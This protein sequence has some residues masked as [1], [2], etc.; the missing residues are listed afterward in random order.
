ML[1]KKAVMLD[2]HMLTH[3]ESLLPFIYTDLLAEYAGDHQMCCFHFWKMEHQVILGMKDTRVASLKEGVQSIKNNS[4]QVVVRNSGGLAVVAD[5]GILNFSIIL[6]QPTDKYS[7]SIDQGY[8]LMKSIIEGAF[9]EFEMDIEAFEVSD[10]YCPGDFD[11]SIN[12][13]KFAG[14]SQRRIKNG[15]GIMIYLSICGDQNKRSEIV[16]EF[17]QTSLGENFGTDGFPPVNPDSMANLSDLLQANL[18]VED[19]KERISH[20]LNQTFDFSE[21]YEQTFKEFLISTEFNDKFEK[22]N[23]RMKQRNQ[24]IDWSENY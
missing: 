13:K 14:I 17:Y 10:S 20:V 2:Q 16:R 8:E 19:A 24:I 1:R 7:F 5:E 18:T 22:Q 12:G 4:Y 11:L 23:E 9:T 21:K 6:P 15:I 3:R